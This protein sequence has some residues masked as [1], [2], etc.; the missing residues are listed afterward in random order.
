[1]FTCSV[2]CRNNCILNII[3]NIT[4]SWVCVL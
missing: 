4:L 3:D 1:L 2:K